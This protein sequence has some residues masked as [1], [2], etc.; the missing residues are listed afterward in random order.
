MEIERTLAP[1]TLIDR[2]QL[3]YL[4]I[5]ALA[6]FLLLPHVIGFD[7]VLRVLRTAH[8]LFI[9][10]AIL[11][12]TLRYVASAGSTIALARL[13]DRRVPLAAMTEAFFAGAA[14]NRTFSTGGAP[15]M[16]VR[17]VFLM[18]HG[19]H[20]GSVAA[21][22]FIEDIA[23][24]VIGTGVFLVGLTTLTS[25]R[26]ITTVIELA[27]GFLIGSMILVLAAFF[28]WRNRAIVERAV[29]G[30]ARRSNKIVE[31]FF[32]RSIYLPDR[33]QQA[34]DD[35]Y[36]GLTAARQAPMY[37]GLSFGFNLIRTIAG[38]TTLY[39]AF[40][41]LEQNV[42]P[43]MAM[44]L[45]TLASVLSTTS[46]VPGE[47]AIMSTGFAILLKSIGLIPKSA[48]VALILSRAISFWLPLIVGY[49]ALFR[50]R[51]HHDL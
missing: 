31:R 20:A 3:I 25:P 34:L 6:V 28:V 48:L 19:V 5:L 44:I 29:H 26:S 43:G 1:R 39:F 4:A 33:V 18:K 10:A 7:Y 23:G 40:V 36:T 32:R 12:E 27:L 37:V 16:F 47:V 38:L 21:I 17:L 8:P 42:A 11:A 15:G 9:L 22:F 30:L 45:S 14:L 35:F 41:A 13:F 50:L 2:R 24:L 51:R 46:A 49:L